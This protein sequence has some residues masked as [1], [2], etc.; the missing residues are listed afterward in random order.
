MCYF[1]INKKVLTCTWFSFPEST[2][3]LPDA[4]A[5]AFR[6]RKVTKPYP[7]DQENTNAFYTI[8][9]VVPDPGLIVDKIGLF[10]NRVINYQLE[11]ACQVKFFDFYSDEKF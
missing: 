3:E 11:V 9:R 5:K 1:F 10:Q 7:P 4:F 2:Q 8:K 6:F